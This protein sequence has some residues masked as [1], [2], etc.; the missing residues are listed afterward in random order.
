M[1]KKHFA[2]L[3]KQIRW[4]LEN[5]PSTRN[6]DIDLMIEIW[7]KY[8]AEWLFAVES[9]KGTIHRLKDIPS[10]E[11]HSPAVLLCQLQNL[12]REDHIKRIRAKI[13]NEQLEFLPTEEAVAKARRYNMEWWHEQ[14]QKKI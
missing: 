7:K 14:M 8:Y 2:G 10:E 5:I 11:K 1:S 13:Q 4:C 9:V 3:T 6:S 12:P